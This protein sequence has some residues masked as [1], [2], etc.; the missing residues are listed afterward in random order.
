MLIFV[1]RRLLLPLTR[2]LRE[3]RRGGPFSEELR[4]LLARLSDW[5]RF[6]GRA[7]AGSAGGMGG[8]PSSP[9]GGPSSTHGPSGG[10]EGA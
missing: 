1:K 10:R 9:S 7:W 8:R 4:A 3:V 5:S 6:A 2:W